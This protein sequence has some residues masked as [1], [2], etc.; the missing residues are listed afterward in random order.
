LQEKHDARIELLRAERQRQPNAHVVAVTPGPEAQEN[1]LPKFN[2]TELV[3]S[4]HGTARGVGLNIEEVGYTLDQTESQPYVRYRMNLSVQSPYPEIR[5]FLAAMASEFQ[6]VSLD[7][8]TC[9]R[10]KTAATT[11]TCKLVFSAFFAKA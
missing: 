8:I 1:L 6:H 5:K 3:G 4:F 9:S 2:A 11:L 10:A 7:A